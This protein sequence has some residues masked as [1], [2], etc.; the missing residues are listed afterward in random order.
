M[1]PQTVNLDVITDIDQLKSMAYDQIA[2]KE[3]AENN[4]K[5][6]NGRIAQIMGS[7]K[8]PDIKDLLPKG[9]ETK[10]IPVS[11]GDASESTA[12]PVDPNTSALPP[13]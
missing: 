6:I 8:A 7:Q 10:V 1:G 9:A 12:E 3:Q 5:N 4:L 2:A 13:Q 11:D